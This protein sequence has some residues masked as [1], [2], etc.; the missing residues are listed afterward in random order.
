MNLQDSGYF[1]Q[2]PPRL[3]ATIFWEAP[4]IIRKQPVAGLK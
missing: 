2:R 4:H 3:P 1:I